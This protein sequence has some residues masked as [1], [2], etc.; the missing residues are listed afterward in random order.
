MAYD[1]YDT[2]RER[3]RGRYQDYDRE[4]G[5]RDERGFFERAGDEISSWFG[6]EEAERRRRQDERM[7]RGPG[8]NREGDSDRYTYGGWGGDPDRERSARGG[9]SRNRDR[10]RFEEE[11]RSWRPMNWTSS[12]R[13]YRSGYPGYG[14]GSD[15]GYGSSGWGG[16]FTGSDYER[17]DHDRGGYDRSEEPWGRDDYRRTSYAGAGRDSDHHYQAWRQQQL[18]EL[19]RDYDEYRRER[20]ERFESDFGTW[21]QGRQQKRGMLGQ[22]REHMD[23][24]GSD[25]ETVGKVDCVKGD[26]IVLTKS[27]SE[28][29]RHHSVKCTMID[30]VEG[31]QVRLEIPAEEAKS[32][33]RDEDERGFFGR[34]NEDRANLERSFAGTYR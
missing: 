13:D 1:R 32:R 24:V 12:N 2:R 11:D 10:E 7:N 3:E 16:A 30:T 8:E 18:N 15:R 4:R 21:R 34:E 26:H 6:D 33:F 14:A 22:I 28:D 27:D 19:D 23:V 17:R 20:Q 25:G 29:N 5:R 9:S 31:D